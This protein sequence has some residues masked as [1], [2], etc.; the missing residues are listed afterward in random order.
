MK[1]KVKTENLFSPHP[2][3]AVPL[4]QSHKNSDA[5]IASPAVKL[6]KVGSGGDFSRKVPS[7]V[8][9]PRFPAASPVSLRTEARDGDPGNHNAAGSAH[10]AMRKI[11][12]GALAGAVGTHVDTRFVNA[13][14]EK[15]SAI[16]R[17]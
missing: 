5:K 12:V 3:Q 15:K 11:A 2:P 7:R 14:A 16:E 17:L 9:P 1:R 8:F 13:A 6:L 10:T 4:P